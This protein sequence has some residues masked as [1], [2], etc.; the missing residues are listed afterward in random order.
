MIWHQNSKS[1][2]HFPQSVNLMSNNSVE[3]AIY[4]VSKWDGPPLQK[5]LITAAK[6]AWN[7]ETYL[8]L[9]YSKRRVLVVRPFLMAHAYINNTGKGTHAWT[10]TNQRSDSQTARAPLLFLPLTVCVSE[11]SKWRG[12][13]S[14]C[15]CV[16]VCVW[17]WDGRIRGR[18]DTESVGD[19]TAF[20]MA[21][22]WKQF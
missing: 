18:E 11:S 2:S 4:L 1:C 19:L 17:V 22:G 10:H 3:L 14:V 12:N 5:R 8:R 9:N 7:H 16:C 6:H 13:E 20:L 21:V 15:V